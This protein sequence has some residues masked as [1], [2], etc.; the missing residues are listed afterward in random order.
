MRFSAILAKFSSW[1]EGARQYFAFLTPAMSKGAS[2]AALEQFGAEGKS[3]YAT[4]ASPFELTGPRFAL[5]LAAMV[6][7]AFPDIVFGSASFVFRD[8]GLFGYP[9]AHYH[10][11]CFWRGEIPLW[12]PL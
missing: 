2:S 4:S 8:Y 6:V 3:K 9:L 7:A 1:K 11:E 12:N 10:R 5:V